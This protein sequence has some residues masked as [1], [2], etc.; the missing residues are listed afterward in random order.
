VIVLGFDT[1]T[2]CTAVGVLL[3][4][5]RA[6]SLREVPIEGARPAHTSRLL[7]LAAELLEQGAV[8]WR[9]VQRVGV[10]VGPGT[11]TGL[12]VG[13]ATARGLGQSLGVAVAGV[14]TLQALAVGAGGAGGV[15]PA[16]RGSPEVGQRV[17]AVIDARRGEVF[18]A[19]YEHGREVL[20]PRALAPERLGE[21]VGPGPAVAVGGG[22][23]R[24][25]VN[26]EAA[27]VAVP[28]DA[29]SAHGV[30]A[31]VICRL[32]ADLQAADLASVVPDYRR[33]PDAEIVLPKTEP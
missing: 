12:R 33:R 9:Q 11:F 13:V 19:A 1:A 18:A 15:D 20:A 10:G 16:G 27:G 3:E 23:V 32:A 30:D 8:S 4:D 2:P 29:S 17:L 21:L 28:P 24:F 26:L 25:R 5:G 31:A 6:L 22:A 7:A 14:S